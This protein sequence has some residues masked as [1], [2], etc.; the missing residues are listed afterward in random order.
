MDNES[1]T[2]K[3]G[4]EK[5][6]ALCSTWMQCHLS[7]A[8]RT[9]AR[10]RYTGPGQVFVLSGKSWLPFHIAS[11]IIQ[12]QKHA[13]DHRKF[14]LRPGFLQD[15]LEINPHLNISFVSTVFLTVG[16]FPTIFRFRHFGLFLHQIK[17]LGKKKCFPPHGR[18]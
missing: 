12:L 17:I 11:V 1:R 10:S 2:L 5:S 4:R 8:G 6:R 13:N 16:D 7:I 18:N 9:T 14:A 3:D 15:V